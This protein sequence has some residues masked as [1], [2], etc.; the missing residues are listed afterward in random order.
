MC[1]EC[2]TSLLLLTKKAWRLF[3]GTEAAFSFLWNMTPYPA[4]SPLPQTK[5]LLRVKPG[6]RGAWMRK[7]QRRWD[8][9]LEEGAP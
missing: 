9:V 1:R 4:G 8:R 2:Q 3:P 5:A 7:Q 6:R